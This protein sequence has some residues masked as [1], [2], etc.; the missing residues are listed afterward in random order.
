[1]LRRINAQ[2]VLGVILA[3]TLILTSLP[4]HAHAELTI[5]EPFTMWSGIMFGDTLED[6]KEK[7]GLNF[8]HSYL[9]AFDDKG[10][11]IGFSNNENDDYYYSA[12]QIS[13]AGIPQATVVLF[14]DENDGLIGL[15]FYTSAYV[16]KVAG[17]GGWT[18]L[19][20]ESN[21]SYGFNKKLYTDYIDLLSIKYGTPSTEDTLP[22]GHALRYSLNKY[23]EYRDYDVCNCRMAYTIWRK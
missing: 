8:Y 1:M 12:E 13:V 15:D 22:I 6:I 11:N 18:E 19:I 7:T 14:F 9:F 4:F 20:S 23:K 17:A 16:N 3:I 21:D 5:E 2:K 10:H